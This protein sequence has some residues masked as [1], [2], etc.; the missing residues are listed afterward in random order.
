M[1]KGF[2]TIT[3]TLRNI[4]LLYIKMR[5][6]MGIEIYMPNILNFQKIIENV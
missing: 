4:T 1:I 2:Q 3:G 5:T 6:A